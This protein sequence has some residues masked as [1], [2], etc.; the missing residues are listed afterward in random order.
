[1]D[2]EY[3]IKNYL[4]EIQDGNAAIFAGAGLSIGAGFVD[5]RNLLKP[6]ADELHLDIT[7]EQDLVSVAQYFCNGYNRSRITQTLIDE[8]GVSPTP[9][10]NHKILASLPIDTYWTTNYDRL[11]ENAL[12]QENKI[13]DSKYRKDQ[14]AYTKRGRDVLLY[15]MHG[16][17]ED[18][19]N[20]I[21]T[22]DEYEKYSFTH[23]PFIT[24]LSGDLVSKT[25]LFLGFSFSDPNLDY[26]LSRVRVNFQDNQRNHYCIFKRCAKNDFDDESE[27]LNASVKQDLVA[28][29][30]KR[31]HINVVFVEEYNEI[32]Q[33][34]EKIYRLFKR[35]TIFISGSADSFGEWDKKD[36][37]DS[38][39]KLGSAMVDKGFRV[40]S[41]I[42]LGIGNALVSG[43]IAKAYK[44]QQSH[45]DD[46]VLMRPF[47]QYIEDVGERRR[48]WRRYREEI[49]SK[50]G[51]AIF[52]MGNK[53]VDGEVVDADGMQQEFEIAVEQGVFVLPIG[54]TGFMSKKLW[55]L[56][57]GNIDKYYSEQ[58]QEFYEKFN[59]LGETIDNPREVISMIIDILD[60]IVKE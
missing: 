12:N 42:G 14:L 50:S 33:M 19:S 1:M 11:I 22:K 54:C 37:E 52:L 58:S 40:A 60:L 16:D 43:A 5:W 56:V 29:D 53:T 26:I 39:F 10:K 13:Y 8:L 30:L 23:A 15:K 7:H 35:K 49:I 18:P 24:A 6:L 48:V 46:H 55:D 31:F 28:Q 25:F 9:T 27:F 21:L 20:T 17:I 4:K 47:P 59:E 36:V 38:L 32:E 44:S 3:F 2:K 34:L 45:L 41:G 51:I 57:I